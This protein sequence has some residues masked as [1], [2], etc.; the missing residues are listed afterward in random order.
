VPDGDGESKDATAA[1]GSD[2]EE[3]FN[4][5]EEGEPVVDP[6]ELRTTR[7]MLVLCRMLRSMR[8]LPGSWPSPVSVIVSKTD[9]SSA[10]QFTF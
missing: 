1:E 6:V 8:L 2:Y 3:E 10:A 9:Y 7:P 5:D 4:E